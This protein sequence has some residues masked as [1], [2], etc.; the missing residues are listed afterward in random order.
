MLVEPQGEKG[1]ALT[2]ENVECQAKFM[3]SSM[4][5]AYMVWPDQK[6]IFSGVTVIVALRE[7]GNHTL[8]PELTL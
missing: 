2:T 1:L 6:I 3:M 4:P 8:T 5:M 7:R